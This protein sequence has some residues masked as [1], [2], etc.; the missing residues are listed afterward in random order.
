VR[1]RLRKRAACVNTVPPFLMVP[2]RR[3]FVIYD[4]IPRG[5]AVLTVQHQVRDIETLIAELM[6]AFLAEVERLKRGIET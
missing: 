6:P 3:H 5:I 2:V 1:R 4:I